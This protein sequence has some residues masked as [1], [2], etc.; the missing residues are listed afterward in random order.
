M[1]KRVAI[2]LAFLLI[3]IVNNDVF[4]DDIDNLKNEAEIL[5]RLVLLKEKKN[6]PPPEVIAQTERMRTVSEA[7]NWQNAYILASLIQIELLL[8]T[9]NITKA[10][11]I[12]N[13]V[14]NNPLILTDEELTIRFQIVDMQI[15]QS[16]GNLEDAPS[17]YAD[18]LEKAVAQD[19][20]ALS[21]K[22]YMAVGLSQYIDGLYADAIQSY[23]LAYGAYEL[24]NVSDNQAKILTT[25][26]NIYA[27][28]EQNTEAIEYF[29]KAIQLSEQTDDKFLQATLYF[30]IG[31]ALKNSGE[32]FDAKRNMLISEALSE[33]IGDDLGKIYA[34]LGIAFIE[35]ELEEWSSALALFKSALPF[36]VESGN[37]RLQLDT[38]LGITKSYAK[39]QDFANAEKTLVKSKALLDRLNGNV[40]QLNYI[41]VAI[42]VYAEQDRFE[43]AFSLLQEKS[44]LENAMNNEMKEKEL[45]SFQVK[46]DTEL[47]E[48]RNENLLIQNQLQALKISEHE[49]REKLRNTVITLVILLLLLV[50][51]FLVF[52]IKNRNHF[53]VMASRDFLTNAPNRRAVIEYAAVL[54]DE[55]VK[56]DMPLFIA[57]IDFDHFK[58]LNDTYGHDAGDTVLRSFAKA[59]TEVL[60]KEDGFGRY[61]GEEWLLVLPGIEGKQVEA[62]FERLKLVMDAL[63][64]NGIPPQKNVTFSMGAAAIDVEKDKNLTDII[65]RADQLLYMAKEQGKNRLVLRSTYFEV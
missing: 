58:A 33:E 45:Q 51:V 11:L 44:E 59:C 10:S 34:T 42:D 1:T 30:N 23:I 38:Q 60:R 46:Y 63:D 25:I 27:D 37:Q 28:Q 48:K 24:A 50:L 5:Q 3:L 18:L 2:T 62:I 19:D 64:I 4:A 32:F 26:G 8:S 17:V 14:S 35:L 53:K 65:A 40:V 7:Q 31:L 39:L 61:G 52:Q 41:K 47:T 21:G 13:E 29:E 54:F 12:Y 57:I 20:L 49:E 22:I 15:R 56:N 43:E 6:Q 9:D 16:S 36:V 55:A